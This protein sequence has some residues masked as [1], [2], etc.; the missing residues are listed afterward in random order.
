VKGYYFTQICARLCSILI[1]RELITALRER[2]GLSERSLY[3][4]IDEKRQEAL[5]SREVAAFLVGLEKGIDIARFASKEQLDLVRSI[6]QKAPVVIQKSQRPPKTIQKAVQV[7]ICGQFEI[8]EPRLPGK[9]LDEAKEMSN[10]YPLLYVFE[11]SVR[12]LIAGT[13]SGAVGP[14]WW[15]KAVP[16]EI[17]NEVT[18]RK[19]AES[20]IPWHGSR[21]AHEIFYT[22]IDHLSRIITNNWKHFEGVLHRQ[23]WVENTISCIE[24]SRNVVAHHNPLSKEDTSRVKVMFRDWIKTIGTI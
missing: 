20:K 23:S 24:A 15:E 13:L 3:R 14:D 22:D 12:N 1:N 16:K 19:Q 2:T 9:L 7:N 17:R 18:K 6:A 8:K 4:S 10:V 5:V 21:G 11:N